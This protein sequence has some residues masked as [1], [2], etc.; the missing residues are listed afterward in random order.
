MLIAPHSVHS[1]MIT[2]IGL[3]FNIIVHEKLILTAI[4]SVC[5]SSNEVNLSL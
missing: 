4:K 5:I 2:L 1:D 3:S